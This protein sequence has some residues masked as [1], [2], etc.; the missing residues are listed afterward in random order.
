MEENLGEY[1]SNPEIKKDLSN[2]YKAQTTK[3]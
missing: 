3:Y 2:T 1:P